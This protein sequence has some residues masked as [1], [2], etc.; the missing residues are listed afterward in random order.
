MLKI[1]SVTIIAALIVGSCAIIAAVIAITPWIENKYFTQNILIKPKAFILERNDSTTVL[2]RVLSISYTGTK[3]VMINIQSLNLLNTKID[4]RYYQIDITKNVYLAGDTI[5]ID[6]ASMEV[7]NNTFSLNDYLRDIDN[8]SITYKLAGSEKS[9]N[10]EF[11]K[12]KYYYSLGRR[13]DSTIIS[14]NSKIYAGDTLEYKIY[15]FVFKNQKCSLAVWPYSSG[16]QIRESKDKIF[17]NYVI[18]TDSSKLMP[19]NI[20]F[21]INTLMPIVLIPPSL[22]KYVVIQEEYRYFLLI[23][24]RGKM[25]KAIQKFDI[26]FNINNLYEVLLY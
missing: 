22:Q 24:E 15:K 10:I 23:E 12:P 9:K 7:P 6:T 4:K 1:K 20:G 2:S 13:I 26:D 19:A 18:P 8:I 25:K 21:E 16:I 5:I 3:K 14:P 11:G 17:I